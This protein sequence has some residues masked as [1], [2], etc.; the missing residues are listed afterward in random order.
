MT[1]SI[2]L[3]REDLKRLTGKMRFSAQ[4]RALDRLRIKYLKAADESRWFVWRRLLLPHQKPNAMAGG[5]T[6]QRWSS[7]AWSDAP[8]PEREPK[9]ATRS[10]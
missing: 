7:T 5:R 3:S 8:E 2:F 9:S 6:G 4:R 1:A 10:E